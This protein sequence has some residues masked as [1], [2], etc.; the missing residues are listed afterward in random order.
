[1]SCVEP[2]E[3]EQ[4]AALAK[5]PKVARLSDRV[6]AL[7]LDT[8]ALLPIYYL[9][10]CFLAAWIGTY[11]FTMPL[12]VSFDLHGGPFFLYLLLLTVVWIAYYAICEATFRKTIGKSIVGIEVQPAGFLPFSAEQA[13]RRNLLRPLDAF[14]FYL[15][16]F[17]AANS[18]KR[19]QTIGDKVANTIVCE[20][21]RPNRRKAAWGGI[22]FFVGGV[23]L[24]ILFGYLF[25]GIRVGG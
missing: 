1:M 20:E 25:I 23:V 3:T 2:L 19:H 12:Q 6:L 14:G 24:N 9:V 21:E 8:V 22:A 18:S 5:P 15:L 10:G 17:L 7:I 16:G 4:I 13:W 11:S